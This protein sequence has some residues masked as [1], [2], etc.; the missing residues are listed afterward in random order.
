MCTFFVSFAPFDDFA[1]W[2]RSDF[3]LCFRMCVCVCVQKHN[4]MY[5]AHFVY[6]RKDFRLHLSAMMWA[7]KKKAKWQK[8]NEK[9]DRQKSGGK[10]PN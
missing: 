9:E 7:M 2:S 4:H 1:A 10:K 6:R 3:H 5:A 8:E